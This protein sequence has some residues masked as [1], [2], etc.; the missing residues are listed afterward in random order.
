ML[1]LY[2]FS[3][4]LNIRK[5]IAHIPKKNSINRQKTFGETSALSVIK[6]VSFT[7]AKTNTVI[8]IWLNYVISIVFLLL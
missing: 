3:N 7:Q 5:V 1:K 6:E 2:N 4:L 8:L